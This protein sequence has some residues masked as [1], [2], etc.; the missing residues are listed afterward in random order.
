VLDIETRVRARRVRHVL[1]RS[2]KPLLQ[3]A[4]LILKFETPLT[5]SA[6]VRH[7]DPDSGQVLGDLP[8]MHRRYAT[9]QR[10][11]H[12]RSARRG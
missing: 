1:A 6:I 11:L 12:G 5:P 3:L 2:C 4:E 7:A 9:R 8:R 10:L